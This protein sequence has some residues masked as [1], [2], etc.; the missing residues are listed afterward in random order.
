M[1]ALQPL[2]LQ[3]PREFGWEEE[4][5][6]QHPT[7]QHQ[8]VGSQPLV[9][10]HYLLEGGMMVQP[11][12]NHQS[13]PP[14]QKL[15][16]REKRTK[17]RYLTAIEIE[18]IVEVDVWEHDFGP[19]WQRFR[20]VCQGNTNTTTT[21]VEGRP[22]HTIGTIAAQKPG[23]MTAVGA[24]ITGALYTAPVLVAGAGSRRGYCNRLGFGSTSEAQ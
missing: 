2:S 5:R 13:G 24:A 18:I 23:L 10:G 11:A 16:R 3:Q 12:E 19:N 4:Q 22:T 20:A 6:Q 9:A 21:R 7:R 8:R 14:R 1:A 15:I 17:P